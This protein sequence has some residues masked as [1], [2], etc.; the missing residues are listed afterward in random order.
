VF[1]VEPYRIKAVEPLK[2][3]TRE[4]RV[5]ALADVGGDVFRLK[6]ADVFIDLF[7]GVGSFTYGGGLHA[8]LLADEALEPLAL[9][10]F[11]G[12]I[13]LNK[14]QALVGVKK[15]RIEA[16]VDAIGGQP[17][18]LENLRLVRGFTLKYGIHVELDVTRAID[19]AWFIKQR[20]Y[21]C[22]KRSV[23]E[24]LEEMRSCVDEVV[25]EPKQFVAGAEDFLS[26]EVVRSRIGQVKYVADK[27]HDAGVPI[28]RPV[29][30]H[31]VF[32]R[33]MPSSFAADLY[34]TAGVR[35]SA[36]GG[37][38]VKLALP[39]LAYTQAHYDLV[40]A[41][42]EATCSGSPARGPSPV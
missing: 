28:V 10:P 19:N 39:Y 42:V 16:T 26:E 34:L 35:V 27:L 2:I 17:I 15:I 13:D 1:P 38:F 23:S 9:L 32:L 4:E 7:D 6:N 36:C 14:L 8:S 25:G 20:E 41:A 31:A 12:D 29:G 33:N 40:C 18:S 5:H 37:G 30:G 11:K 3:L 24:I 22:Q 21:G